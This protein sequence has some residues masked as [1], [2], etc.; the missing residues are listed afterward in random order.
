M[1]IHSRFLS[2]FTLIVVPS[3]TRP[4]IW[5]WKADSILAKL[6]LAI[7]EPRISFRSHSKAGAAF[8]TKKLAC[9]RIA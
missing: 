3:D 9:N 8:L 7:A 4:F 1:L 2:W 5:Y 6:S